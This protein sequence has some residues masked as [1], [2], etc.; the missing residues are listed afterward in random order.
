MSAPRRRPV[1]ANAPLRWLAANGTEL[2]ALTGTDTKALLAIAACWELFA[3]TRST[4]VL[5]AIR[6]LLAEMQPSTAPLTRDLIARS[7]D[8]SDRDRYWPLVW[9]PPGVGG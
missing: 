3:Y 4:G 7:M 6:N 8:W 1:L 2:A 9:A 5:N